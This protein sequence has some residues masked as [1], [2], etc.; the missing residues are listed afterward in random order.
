M[1]RNRDIFR[2]PGAPTRAVGF[3]LGL[4]VLAVLSVQALH[5]APGPQQ[6]SARVVAIGDIH[7]DS[8]SFVN[9]L[10]HAGLIDERL[11]WSGGA[12]TLV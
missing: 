2:S 1:T 7:G 8:D 4:A 12:A 11:A 6:A 3:A 5:A 10:R 9:I